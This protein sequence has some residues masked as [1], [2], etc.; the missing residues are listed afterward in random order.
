VSNE[1]AYGLWP[2]VIVHSLIVIIFAFSFSH[3]ASRR[4]WR[5]FGSFSAFI[6]ALFTEMY[7]FPLSLYL[8]SGWLGTRFPG[9]NLYSHD[10]GHIWYVLL[11]IKGDP[12]SHPLHIL[13]N[14]LIA[15]GFLLLVLAWHV[16]YRAQISGRLAT[17][18]PYA[19]IRHPQYAAFIIIM[20]G[21]LLQ[22][23]ALST[24]V[25]FPFLVWLY[26]RLARR[27]E[28][29]MLDGE[30]AAA[31]FSHEYEDYAANTPAFFPRLRF[32]RQAIAGRSGTV[33]A[34]AVAVGTGVD[35]TIQKGD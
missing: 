30:V 2:L 25:I 4:D 33:G 20:L 7:G 3:P 19:V 24:V 35:S 18:G 34:A 29:E 6:I 11:G 15:G 26:V 14:L 28:R 5:C 9:V 22:W 12:H 27:E 31:A 16:L 23:P 21:F 32:S 10:A 13:S 8:L 17:S 1:Y